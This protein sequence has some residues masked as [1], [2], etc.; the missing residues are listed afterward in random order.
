MLLGLVVL[1]QPV[2]IIAGISFRER[3]PVQGLPFPYASADEVDSIRGPL[4]FLRNVGQIDAEDVWYYLKSGD[5]TVYFTGEG[6][7]FDL[8]RPVHKPENLSIPEDRLGFPESGHGEPGYQRTVFTLRFDQSETPLSY[9]GIYPLSATIRSYTGTPREWAE[10]IPV[11]QE[12]MV[13]NVYP[14]I[15]L[16]WHEKN[17]SLGYDLII[18]PGCSPEMIALTYEGIDALTING[19]QL[20]IQAGE[21]VTIQTAPV[22]FQEVDGEYQEVKGQFLLKGLNSF[23]FQ[24]EKYDRS[25]PLVID[26]TLVY[27]TFWGTINSN[28][29]NRIAADK[30]GNLYVFQATSDGS[31]P[32]EN[33]YQETITGS[34]DF[35]LSKFSADGQRLLFSTFIGGSSGETM[36]AVATDADG[37]VFIAGYST[38]SDYP[39]LEGYQTSRFA[40]QDVVVSKF[41]ADGE[42]LYSTYLGGNDNERPYGLFIDPAGMA[43][44]HGYTWSSNFPTKNAYQA[45]KAG[46]YDFF[47]SKLNT[48]DSGED[49]LIFST[50]Y[51]GVWLDRGAEV[52]A[53]L[54]H[55]YITGQSVSN[56]IPIVNGFDDSYNGP[57]NGGTSSG[58]TG[59]AFLAKFTADGSELLYSSYLGGSSSDYGYG[60]VADAD[61]CAYVVGTT[62][63]TNFPV[64]NAIQPESGGM[65]DFFIAKIDTTKNGD[66][67][68]LFSTYYG[69]SGPDFVNYGLEL[70]GHGDIIL[71]GYTIS[72]DFPS[73][74]TIETGLLEYYKAFILKLSN[75]GQE[76]LYFSY[77]GG[78][79]YHDL[80]NDLALDQAGFFW[81]AGVTL[82]AD[83]PVTS[84]AYYTQP[85]GNWDIFLARFWDELPYTLAVYQDENREV[86][87]SSFN[88]AHPVLYLRATGVNAG[89]YIAGYY[90]ADGTLVTR[91]EVEVG[92]SGVFNSSYD[93]TPFA[94]ASGLW[95][96]AV[97]PAFGYAA[98]PTD[99]SSLDEA[100]YYRPYGI[101]A[102]S[103]FTVDHVF[104][105][106][107][108]LL[109]PSGWS[110]DATQPVLRFNKT[111]DDYSG[112][113]HYSVELDG[114]KSRTYVL[115][116][117]PSYASGEFFR[118]VW[119]DD[120]YAKVEYLGENDADFG[121]DE[122]EVTFK[123]LFSVG[124]T[125]GLHSWRVWTAD[126][127]GNALERSE[128]FFLDQTA[129]SFEDV[130]AEEIGILARGQKYVI[131]VPE[132]GLS[133]LGTVTDAYRGSTVINPDGTRD[134]FEAV[135]SGLSAI[136]LSVR[137][138]SPTGSLVQ[139]QGRNEFCYE[140]T[141]LLENYHD[142]IGIEKK[143]LFS[144]NV[145]YISEVQEYEVW[146]RAS[147]IAGNCGSFGPVH[148][149]AYSRTAVRNEILQ[150]EAVPTDYPK[151]AVGD[152]LP[153][154]L[155]IEVGEVEKYPY[156]EMT[157]EEVSLA[158]DGYLVR[159]VVV[160][161]K[162]RP[163]QGAVVTLASEPRT[164]TS[165]ENGEVVFANVEPGE[166]T[167]TIEY[168]NRLAQRSVII[169]N[170]FVIKEQRIVV[171]IRYAKIE[172]V[173]W[174][175]L[176]AIFVSLM[177]LIFITSRNKRWK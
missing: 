114:N 63:S 42:L 16:R 19:G 149:Q 126:G 80:G 133:L 14:G 11:F 55:V 113:I 171:E 13:R 34:S 60:L 83:F 24:V 121:N 41:S 20:H 62:L 167:L 98:L 112:I 130:R 44:V 145:P 141:W 18:Q 117:L 101:V 119:R 4:M 166:H 134:T 35:T 174:A 32:I 142:Q 61:G 53:D 57:G 15:D 84:D 36:G 77:F 96:V 82:S 68:L 110:H 144:V 2:L 5:D 65:T 6:L 9:E 153:R 8:L 88:A 50:Y 85:I 21:I 30:A 71:N 64:K 172:L 132:T 89:S 159:V 69:G 118:Y 92:S 97:Q 109:S 125:E 162:S 138:Y 139:T 157:D 140:K 105:D 100:D 27:A 107:L 123:D 156:W 175:C 25:F 165:N 143:G 28:T 135:S 169:D 131:S 40:F 54:N 26:P 76:V 37:N 124:L 158:G 3:T 127:A 120:A 10:Q 164:K 161:S 47:L 29:S 87:T 154:S 122:V 103:Q 74:N 72:A 148:F 160:N 93:V 43:Y 33:A 177:I 86:Q 106:S 102:L 31:Y 1:A 58:E 38:S 75:D 70:N 73:A 17:G 67:S 137:C 7:V 91:A 39:I 173:L 104:P 152:F 155:D 45:S 12:L 90:R 168:K 56:D 163:V 99:V 95:T 22:F 170:D 151:Q 146:L 176:G 49:S 94:D 81:I 128:V 116:Y 23:G 48:T 52:W 108:N 46:G 79:E 111:T 147:D 150:P 129:P 136:E 51:G 78:D 59:D 66:D 115:D